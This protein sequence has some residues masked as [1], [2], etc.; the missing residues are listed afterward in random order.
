MKKRNKFWSLLP[1]LLLWA[2]FSVLL[3]GSVFVRITDAPRENKITLYADAQVPRDTA[4]SVALEEARA[5]GIRMVQARPFSYAMFDGGPL[6]TADLLI[7]PASHVETYRDWLGFLP[8][9]MVSLGECL[10]RDG[11]PWG[12]K[13]Y[14]VNAHAG[15][16]SAYIAYEAMKNPEDYYLFFGVNSIHIEDGK[17]AQYAKKLLTL[18]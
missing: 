8:E 15:A 10:E 13:I 5:E 18:E 14:D 7:V 12:L 9:E 17:A 6:E 11:K 1:A 4:L 2:I 3:W 16:A